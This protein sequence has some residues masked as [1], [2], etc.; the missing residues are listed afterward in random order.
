MDDPVAKLDKAD[1]QG[2][3]GS[4]YIGRYDPRMGD[5]SATQGES[6]FEP[7]HLLSLSGYDT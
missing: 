5:G 3:N 2:A 1:D 6:F 7:I 4:E